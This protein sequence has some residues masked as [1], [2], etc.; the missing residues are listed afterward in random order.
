MLQNQKIND[1]ALR[2]RAEWAKSLT[3]VLAQCH[4]ED[5]AAICV[6][7][8]QTVETQGP[9]IGDPFGI[10]VSNARLWVAAAPVH[11]VVAYGL[12]ALERLPKSHLSKPAQKRAF[13]ALWRRFTDAGRAAFLARV[14]ADGQFRRGKE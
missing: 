1:P 14:D 6:A 8:L 11:E 10:T 9:I 3:F 13:V 2:L 5:A 12:A 4:P 7:F